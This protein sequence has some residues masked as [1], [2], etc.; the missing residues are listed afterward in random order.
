M[1]LLSAL[2]GAGGQRDGQHKNAGAHQAQQDRGQD[3]ADDPLA[4]AIRRFILVGVIAQRLLLQFVRA[5]GHGPLPSGSQFVVEGPQHLG[6]K[7]GI[8]H[9]VVVRQRGLP[10][11]AGS[12]LLQK[13]SRRRRSGNGSRTPL[14][15]LDA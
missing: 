2:A 1:R 12:L 6:R 7:G 14:D 13:G 11:E 5:S 15:F 10:L 8:A 3:N 9:F 4:L